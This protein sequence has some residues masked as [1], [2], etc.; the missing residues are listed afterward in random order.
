METQEKQIQIRLKTTQDTFAVPDSTLSVPQNVNPDKLNK[1]VHNLLQH[2]EN[3]PDFDFFISDDLLRS[4]LGEFIQDRTDISS[5]HVLDILY[6]EQK[7]APEPQNSV[8][9]DDWVSGVDV[10]NG[11]ILSACYDNTVCLWDTNATK[12]L[13][14]PGHVSPVRAVKFI[15][16]DEEQNA[17]FAS[18]S[19]DQTLVLYQYKNASNTVE[20]MNVGKGHARSVDCLA[21]D[22]SKQYIATGS[23]DSTLNIWGAKLTNV[24][25]EVKQSEVKKAKNDKA[26]TRTPLITLVGHKEGIS[27]VTYMETP[28]DVITAS[29]DHTL[30]L[31]DAETS[32]LKTELVGNKAF[33]GLA[34]SPEKKMILT[35]ACERTIRMYDP[36][37]TDGLIVKSAY[38]S[39]QGW[40]TSVNWCQGNDHMFVSGSHD[41]LLKMWDVRACKTPLFDL[42]G[43]TDQVLCCSWA[44]P[45]IIVSGGADNDMKIFKS[46]ITAK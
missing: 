1:L 8:N 35:A 6:L 22:P 37:S 40:I 26:P 12:K 20:Y 27:G 44:D 39:H 24:D 33:L 17:T 5:E 42:K 21:V 3:V 10:Q 14:I 13:Q 4:S 18:V 32:S 16:V 34:Y 25:E 31:W 46:N 23:F 7:A 43:H 45:Q 38:S 9:H 11:L 28:T 19:H 36:R 30:R 15:T 29:W 2:V 41:S